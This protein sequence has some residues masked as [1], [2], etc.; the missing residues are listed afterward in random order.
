MIA[1]WVLRKY[2]EIVK[3]IRTILQSRLMKRTKIPPKYMNKR[4]F[5]STHN[6][7]NQLALETRRTL[8]IAFLSRVINLLWQ[9]LRYRLKRN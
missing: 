7:F 3:W 2:K 1:I 4:S 5:K 9:S 8:P 6:S